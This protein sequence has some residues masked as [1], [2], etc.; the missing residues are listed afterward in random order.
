MEDVLHREQNRTG[1]EKDVIIIKRIPQTLT[2]STYVVFIK[3][4]IIIGSP[5]AKPV[6]I[7]IFL[8]CLWVRESVIFI[9]F[10]VVGRVNI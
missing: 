6:S 7:E 5:L 10:S 3:T 4:K 8:S 2:I 9:I 1:I